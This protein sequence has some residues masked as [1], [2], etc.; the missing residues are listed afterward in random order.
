[1]DRG[2]NPPSGNQDNLISPAVNLLFDDLL[3]DDRRLF[4]IA[5][6]HALWARHFNL[7]ALPQASVVGSARPSELGYQYAEKR[8]GTGHAGACVIN[9]GG[10][11]AGESHCDGAEGCEHPP[12]SSKLLR[13]DVGCAH[14]VPTSRQ[15]VYLVFVSGP[16]QGLAGISNGTRSGVN[17]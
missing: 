3:Y 7:E 11:T 13:C 2:L 12:C 17:R 1:M 4:P 16:A 9:Q 6:D 8:L 10:N 5:V 15:A 14:A